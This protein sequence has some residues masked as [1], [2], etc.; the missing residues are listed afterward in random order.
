MMNL[1]NRVKLDNKSATLM[2][3]NECIQQYVLW[4]EFSAGNFSECQNVL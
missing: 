1:S 3:A 4:I 2:N